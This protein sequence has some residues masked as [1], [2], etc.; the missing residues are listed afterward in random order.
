MVVQILQRL[1]LLL[2]PATV[3]VTSNE[4]SS[5]TTVTLIIPRLVLLQSTPYTWSDGSS[6]STTRDFTSAATY[7]VTGTDA[8]NGCTNTADITITVD[9]TQP[10]VV[11]TNN[12]TASSTEVLC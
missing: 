7:T 9:N 12:E 5:A 10:T 11:I 4:T 8:S 6:T 2:I 1:L 3:V